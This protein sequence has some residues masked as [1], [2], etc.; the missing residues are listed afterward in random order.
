MVSVSQKMARVQAD[1]E[2]RGEGR[3]SVI[4]FHRGPAVLVGPLV[5]GEGILTCV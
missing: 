5:L 2:G 4:A 1:G 3:G